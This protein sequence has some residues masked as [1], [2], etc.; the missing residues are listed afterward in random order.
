MSDLLPGQELDDLIARKVFKRYP[1]SDL[2]G[3]VPY[4]SNIADAWD[5][6]EFMRRQEMAINLYAFSPSIRT[7]HS[8]KCTI[9]RDLTT[10]FTAMG[11]TAEHAICLAA[12][13]VIDATS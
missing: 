13:K 6:L 9:Q 10:T 5:V 3:W 7:Q 2:K 11:K 8:W 4:S 12:L 1:N